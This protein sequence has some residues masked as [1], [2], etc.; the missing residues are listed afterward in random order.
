MKVCSDLNSDGAQ[1]NLLI[2]GGAGS[3]RLRKLWLKRPLKP[4]SQKTSSSYW[5]IY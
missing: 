5:S 1:S 2:A 3:K 4:Q